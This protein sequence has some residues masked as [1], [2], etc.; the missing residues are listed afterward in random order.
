MGKCD[1]EAADLGLDENSRSIIDEQIKRGRENRVNKES[2]EDS[3]KGLKEDAISV[4]KAKKDYAQLNKINTAKLESHLKNLDNLIESGDPIKDSERFESLQDKIQRLNESLSNKKDISSDF[5]EKLGSINTRLKSLR[6]EKKSV[7]EIIRHS[8]TRLIEHILNDKLK[9]ARSLIIRQSFM[10][11]EKKLGNFLKQSSKEGSLFPEKLVQEK[12]VTD[13]IL[14]HSDEVK[15]EGSEN[16]LSSKSLQGLINKLKANISQQA[17]AYDVEKE[18]L[19]EERGYHP[20]TFNNGIMARMFGA[21]AFKQQ[22]SKLDEFKADCIKAFGKDELKRMITDDYTNYYARSGLDIVIPTIDNAFKKF[23]I[24]AL[25]GERRIMSFDRPKFVSDEATSAFLRKYSGM[26][27]ASNY[28]EYARKSSTVLASYKVFGKRFLDDNFINNKHI[29]KTDKERAEL[30]A[31]RDNFYGVSWMHPSKTHA[32]L[33]ALSKF[34]NIAALSHAVTVTASTFADRMISKTLTALRFTNAGG[35]QN[36]ATNMAHLVGESVKTTLTGGAYK[37]AFSKN[38]L[39]NTDE[40]FRTWQTHSQW[41]FSYSLGNDNGKGLSGLLMHYFEN[42][43]NGLRVA[44]NKDYTNHIKD[45]SDLNF[46][47]LKTQNRSIYNVMKDTHHID[48]SDWDTLRNYVKTHDYLDASDFKSSP[49]M[50]RKIVSMEYQQSLSAIPNQTVVANSW[51][52]LATNNHPIVSRTL[53]GFW[54][55]FGKSLV[56]SWRTAQEYAP[57]S[58]VI[59]KAAT[60]LGLQAVGGFVPNYALNVMLGTFSGR[61]LQDILQDPE[62]YVSAVLGPIGRLYSIGSALTFNQSDLGYIVEASPALQ[63]V[64]HTLN[65]AY[66]TSTGKDPLFYWMKAAMTVIPGLGGTPIKSYL[67]HQE[68]HHYEPRHGEDFQDYIQNS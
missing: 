64:H 58:S 36:V 53:T 12:L 54:S 60:F 62:T 65:A 39:N 61:K 7:N 31:H 19:P 45:Y 2:I 6:N 32:R 68:N 17:Q 30:R 3:I 41:R 15:K 11:G 18:F 5:K 51:A 46:E 10:S 8:K 63:V 25:A 66:H 37:H 49:S 21:R 1:I 9:E 52:T 57:G 35:L 28:A 14:E 38:F 44:S 43:D 20:V 42:V 4:R 47:Q 22:T 67:L 33:E 40:F 26:S 13:G 16:D 27:V 55:F 23:E 29:T 59:G 24:Q 48:D 50:M 34:Q 56:Q